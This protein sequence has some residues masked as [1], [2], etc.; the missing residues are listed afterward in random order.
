VAS[1][2]CS[3]PVAAGGDHHRSTTPMGWGIEGS[4][5]IPSTPSVGPGRSTDVRG[6]EGWQCQACRRAGPRTNPVDRDGGDRWL[7][8]TV[9][10]VGGQQD[11]LSDARTICPLMASSSRS[12]LASGTARSPVPVTDWHF[13][14]TQRR[15]TP[16]SR[17]RYE[18]LVSRHDVRSPASPS[19]PRGSRAV[20]LRARRRLVN[21]C[22]GADLALS[23][24]RDG[25][26]FWR[27]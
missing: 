22:R 27:R 21:E 26:T 20:V 24:R 15:P 11:L 6:D 17:A 4:A 7:P 19:P 8:K 14:D 25:P 5:G 1:C 13:G 12:V 16:C 3:R 2:A 10:A 18:T 23:P 9:R